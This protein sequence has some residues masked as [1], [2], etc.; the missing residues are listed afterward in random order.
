MPVATALSDARS[1]ADVPRTRPIGRPTKIVR[2]A[3]APRMRVSA[4]LI[5]TL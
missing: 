5:E 3:I 1:A 2:P 4:V